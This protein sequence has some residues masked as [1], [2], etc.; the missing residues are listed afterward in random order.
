MQAFSGTTLLHQIRSDDFLDIVLD[1]KIVNEYREKEL[2]DPRG[3]GQKKSNRIAKHLKENEHIPV[4]NRDV[5]KMEIRDKWGSIPPGF[6]E[7]YK[8]FPAN[9]DT[10]E[11][12]ES[13]SDEDI[14]YRR[15]LLSLYRSVT[16][17]NGGVNG[18]G[19]RNYSELLEYRSNTLLTQMFF[20]IATSMALGGILLCHNENEKWIKI[21]Q[22]HGFIIAYK[23]IVDTGG[24]IDYV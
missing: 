17:D 5:Y 7:I 19:V 4:V 14:I 12:I 13:L 15:K 24:Y 20:S 18:K 22:K 10:E 16:G 11:D 9:S 8:L 2:T 23:R 3:H 1:G 21:A 6:I